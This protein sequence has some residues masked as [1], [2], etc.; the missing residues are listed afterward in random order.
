MTIQQFAEASGAKKNTVIDWQKDLSSP[1]AAKLA[2]L[3][4]VGID[5]LYIIAGQRSQAV[6][7]ENPRE[8]A[9]LDNYRHC[10]EEDR[11]AI[12]RVALNAASAKQGSL[13]GK[14]GNQGL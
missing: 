8:S 11:A 14:M 2:P 1:P 12:D 9:L 4:S 6:L 5:V 13:S 10:R 3:V 7:P